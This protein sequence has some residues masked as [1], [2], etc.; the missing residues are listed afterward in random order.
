M[1]KT[2]EALKKI[3]DTRSNLSR[4]ES[5]EVFG[6]IMSGAVEGALLAAFLTALK[7]KGET[8]D[9][10]VGAAQAM[11][12]K[13]F[14]IDSGARRPI[15][16]CGTGGDGLDT[17]NISTASAFIAAGAGVCVAKHGN[18]AA[19]SKCGSADVLAELG[20]NLDVSPA[21]MEHCLQL[22]GIAFLFAP[23]MHPAMRYAAPVR[24]SLGFRTI[25]NILGPLVNPAGAK[26]QLVG[27]FDMSHTE[28]LA[29]CLLRLGVGRALVVHGRDG[30]DEISPCY[31]TRVSELRN[32][33]VKT[34]E[35][36]PQR[37]LGPGGNFS[38]LRG[39]S[40]RENAGKILSI[41][42]GGEAGAARSACILNA[43]AAIVVGGGA[44]SFECGLAMAVESIE[45]GAA[46]GKLK[47]LV[48]FSRQ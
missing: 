14:F 44:D 24:K 27:V 28:I 7:M 38:D 16:T 36:N 11:R 4:L 1:S 13:A 41:L 6:E 31:P 32:G 39:G 46:M 26:G 37:Y 47:T 25:F 10:I 42:S 23:K 30:L 45:S 21:V 9:E 15:D 20:F 5:M 34:Y 43:A 12:S 22:H 3:A 40:P 29:E 8:V 19:T 2:L 48:E 18:R 33:M 17:F 35:L